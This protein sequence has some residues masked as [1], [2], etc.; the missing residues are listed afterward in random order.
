MYGRNLTNP[1]PESTSVS[2]AMGQPQKFLI[3]AHTSFILDT[4]PSASN[5]LKNYTHDTGQFD[6]I[7]LDPPWHNKA[8]S[9]LKRKKHLSYNTMKDILSELPP[10]GN[11]LAPGGIVGIWCTNNVN[12]INKIKTIL[13]KRWNVELIAEWVWLKVFSYQQS[14]ADRKVTSRGEPVV[15]LSSTFRKPYEILL[16]ARKSSTTEP[17]AI[18]DRKVVIAV[19]TYHSQK[20]CLKGLLN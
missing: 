10:V 16:L 2:I 9:R 7:L 13:C 11:W 18:P 20:P 3:P 19:P 6:L 14:Q 5:A 1:W 8:V 15:D 4:F 12:M 17:I